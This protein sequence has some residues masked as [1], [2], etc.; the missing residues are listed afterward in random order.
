MTADFTAWEAVRMTQLTYC[1]KDA[2][3][4]RNAMKVMGERSEEAD[5]AGRLGRL[6][7]VVFGGLGF[8]LQQT[9]GMV[10][11]PLLGCGQQKF[12]YPMSLQPSWLPQ[13]R[14]LSCWKYSSAQ[15]HWLLQQ[16]LAGPEKNN[17]QSTGHCSS[18]PTTEVTS[19]LIK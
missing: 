16:D 18:L 11:L 10:S 19:T 7:V 5:D 6:V 15:H 12:P 1:L 8:S 9:L 4:I 2:R 13:G 3:T 17:R 14:D